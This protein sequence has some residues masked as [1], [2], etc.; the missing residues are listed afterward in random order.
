MSKNFTKDKPGVCEKFPGHPNAPA[1]E[2]AFQLR[3]LWAD[4]Y[5]VLMHFGGQP[6][7]VSKV[8][9]FEYSHCKNCDWKKLS[10]IIDANATIRSLGSVGDEPAFLCR[11]ENVF[12]GVH[13]E[14]EAVLQM[15]EML[16]DRTRQ[17]MEKALA[18]HG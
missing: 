16:R 8:L 10:T 7:L 18:A 5:T 11:E 6:Q 12:T 17:Y 2:H 4:T 13:G 15:M 3:A 1:K 14:K 9:P